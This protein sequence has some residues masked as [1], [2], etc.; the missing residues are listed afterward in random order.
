MKFIDFQNVMSIPRMDR[1]LAA[2]GGNSRTAMTLY[3]LNLKLSQELF[4]LV[5]CFEIALRNRI[6]WHYT[7]KFGPHWLR[8]A[9]GLG[10]IFNSTHCGKTPYIIAEA[11][12]KLNPY[13]HSK[14]IAELDFG[15]WRYTFARHQF[16]AGGQSLLAIF[17]AKPLSTMAHKYNHTYIFSELEKVNILRNRLAHHEPI[18]FSPGNPIKDTFFSRQRY[19]TILRLFQWMQIDE[20]ALLYGIDHVDALLDRIDKL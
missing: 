14:L 9:A 15:F 8:N 5:S 18:C 11:I 1:Y 12:R 16:Y 13:S 6:D 7:A 20:K 2:M 19:Q 17:S 4:T 10:G 3:R